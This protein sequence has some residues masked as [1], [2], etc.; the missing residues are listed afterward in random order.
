MKKKKLDQLKLKK[1]TVS[2]LDQK[3]NGG[4]ASIIPITITI[5]GCPTFDIFCQSAECPSLNEVT[6][7]DSINICIA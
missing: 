2:K 6:C 5:V 3:V 1:T 4:A 7:A